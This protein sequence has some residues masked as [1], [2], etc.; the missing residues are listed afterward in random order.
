MALLN[1]F[2]PIYHHS[3]RGSQ[4]CSTEYINILKAN[5]IIPSMADVGLS[6]D[7]PHAES[8]NR[9]IKEEEVCYNYYES[10]IEAKE[11]IAKYILVYNTER[12]HSS[13]GYISPVEYESNY[14]QTLST[15]ISNIC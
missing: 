13:I 1:N 2:P 11:S 12:L 5:N 8:L 10:F 6:I 9:S 14:Y 3:D 4:Y 7:N 15:N